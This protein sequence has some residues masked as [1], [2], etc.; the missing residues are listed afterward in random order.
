MHFHKKSGELKKLKNENYDNR[1]VSLVAFWVCFTIPSCSG[2]R[3]AAAASGLPGESDAA[4]V[5][6]EKR[7]VR[8][9]WLLDG[10][11]KAAELFSCGRSVEE[12]SERHRGG[13]QS[14]QPSIGD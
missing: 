10:R 9:K 5:G 3:S 8:S 11:L 12:S 1:K 7:S 4:W 6:S 14:G 13:R 2:R